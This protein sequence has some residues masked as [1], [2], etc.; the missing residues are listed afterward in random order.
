MRALPVCPPKWSRAPPP[1]DS[2]PAGGRSAA[3]KGGEVLEQPRGLGGVE[4]TLMGRRHLLGDVG[5]PVPQGGLRVVAR[6]F[7]TFPRWLC[8]RVSAAHPQPGLV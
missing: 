5:G 2:L 7:P 3:P 8:R 6:G 1:Q 4:Q